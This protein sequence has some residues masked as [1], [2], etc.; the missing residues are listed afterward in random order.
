MPLNPVKIA[1]LGQSC[2]EYIIAKLK[3]DIDLDNF[4]RMVRKNCLK[5]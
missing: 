2:H 3:N 5:F 4:E 1:L